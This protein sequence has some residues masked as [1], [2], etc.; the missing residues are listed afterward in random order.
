M[1]A[2]KKNKEGKVKLTKEQISQSKKLFSYLK[3]YSFRFAVGGVLLM[4]STS[5]GLIFPLMLGQ[6]LGS[7]NNH[8]N[9]QNMQDA[10]HLI[11]TDNI[12][13]VAVALFILFGIQ[14]VFSFF[15]VVVFNDFTE[16]VMRDVRKRTFD[17]LINKPVNFFHRHTVGELTSRMTS[18]ISQ[19]NETLRVTLG[20]F[21]RTAI[22]IVGGIGF[23]AYISWQLSL[24]MLATVPVMA[25]AAIVFGKY[26]K[27]L[28]KDAQ[29]E[30]AK[31][32]TVVEETLS[33]ITNVKAF[34]NE[35]FL[36]DRYR[37]L[38]ENIR[39]LNVKSGLWRG[40][41][42]SF[43]I[44][45][46]FGS[47][48]FVIW[49]GLLMTQGANPALTSG[50]FYSFILLTIMIAGSIGSLP[51]MY[52][53]IQKT[54]GATA[55]LMDIIEEPIED[56]VFKGE[57]K[58][59]IEGNIRFENVNFH[60][61]N[62]QDVTVLKNISIQI[63][64]NQTVALVGASGA[65]KSTI[66]SL[67]QH[68]YNVSEGKILFEQ[69]DIND[70]NLHHLR[71]SIAYVPQEVLLF[72][73]TIFENIQFGK[74]DATKEEVI[75][76]AEL[77]NAWSFI[78]SFPEGLE[79]KVG[80]RGVQLS[81]GQKQRIAI[82]RAILK[83]PKI[84]ILDEATSALDSASER[85]VQDALDKL[86]I[87]RTS[88]VIAHRLSTIKNADQILV[89]ENGEIKE[90]GTHYELMDKS[91]GIYSKLIELQELN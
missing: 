8:S 58:P 74:T 86:M 71:K 53:N 88:V 91:E 27:K 52:T 15:K 26:I 48:V 70:I 41:F 7:G 57:L 82:A 54:I 25:I 75:K 35:L 18:D 81:G 38:I 83:N 17:R 67:I 5:I 42:V 61:E 73:G 29:S 50:D 79:T 20:E 19:L 65:G 28:A 32:N 72:A 22:I 14:A 59:N 76:A 64:K 40:A 85:L 37:V 46:I 34:T 55:H 10:V 69:I 3:P 12:S 84:L 2:P 45:S 66:A 9:M 6:L 87:G 24:Y 36:N 56:E 89:I 44:F 23:L 33:G 4:I 51:E 16:L 60:Y 11:N 68:F 39:R 78:E 47:I 77:A 30:T 1:F 43:I 63:N 90:K 49:Q 13:S 31:S 21:F 62:R 80:D